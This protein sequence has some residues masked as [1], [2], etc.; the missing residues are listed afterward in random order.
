V[1]EKVTLLP[2][3]LAAIIA[4]TIPPMQ[5]P[6]THCFIRTIAI[7]IVCFTNSCFA[8]QWQLEKQQGNVAVFSVVG[9][10]GYKEV[11][12]KTTLKSDL[13]ALLRLLNDV[14][15]A[16]NWIANAIQVKILE[17]ESPNERLVHTFFNAPWPIKNRDMVT[18][19][20]TEEN[21]NS[22]EI[23]IFDKGNEYPLEPDFVRMQDMFGVWNVSNTDSNEI[24]IS[25]QGGGNPAGNLPKWLANKVLIDATFDTFVNLSEVILLG[26]YQSP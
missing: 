22:I 26:K 4:R 25:Y 19:S 21:M 15:F 1:F 3:E 12:A 2:S 6:F 16:P 20:K 14:G 17:A 18:Y 10:S 24:E 9:E 23:S 7:A 8:E 11:L 5:Y 13:S